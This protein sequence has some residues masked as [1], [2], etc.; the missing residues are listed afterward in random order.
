MINTAIWRWFWFFW[1][2]CFLV[3]FKIYFMKNLEVPHLSTKV[4][5]SNVWMYVTK[6]FNLTGYFYIIGDS[7]AG[8]RYV[9]DLLMV[10]ILRCLWQKKYVGDIFLHVGDNPIGHQHHNMPE[11]DVDDR[12]NMLE[13]W[14]STWRKLNNFFSSLNMRFLAGDTVWN[15]NQ[16]FSYKW[17]GIL[18]GM[19][20]HT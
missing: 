18:S 8:Y 11:C 1:Y 4:H 13:T 9:G 2:V 5:H 16:T 17:R 7:Y 14:N 12:Y 19:L 10:T 20:T 3:L 15:K 6:C